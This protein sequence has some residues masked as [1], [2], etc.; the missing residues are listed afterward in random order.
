MQSKS[1][2]RCPS[3]ESWAMNTIKAAVIF[4]R[5][6]I[7]GIRTGSVNPWITSIT[8][9]ARCAP[10]EEDYTSGHVA[11]AAGPEFTIR[12]PMT[13]EESGA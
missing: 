8:Y 3:H 4:G 9:A 5:P 7:R 12:W 10:R 1:D 6:R 2:D 11:N 13:L